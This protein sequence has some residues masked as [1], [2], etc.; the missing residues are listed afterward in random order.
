MNFQSH[1][2]VMY[3]LFLVEKQ[4]ELLLCNAETH[5]LVTIVSEAHVAR[6][7]QIKT[8]AP[9]HKTNRNRYQ[10]NH[11]RDNQHTQ[12]KNN[13]SFTNSDGKRPSETRS[14]HKCGRVG[15]PANVCQTS[16]YFVKMFQENKK[17]QVQTREAH[18]IDAS[19]DLFGVDE[20]DPRSYVAEDTSIAESCYALLDSATTYTILQLHILFCNIRNFFIQIIFH[21]GKLEI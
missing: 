2:D 19:M 3:L 13:S 14:C 18:T 7:S 5:S 8:K 16:K 6:I 21:I 17:F 4:N 20:E 1:S 12:R 9:K 10:R 15:H 11:S